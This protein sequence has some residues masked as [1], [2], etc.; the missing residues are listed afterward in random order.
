MFK[1]IHFGFFISLTTIVLADYIRYTIT[2]NVENPVYI[3]E[4]GWMDEWYCADKL[5]I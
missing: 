5:D 4:V 2:R 1:V 3:G